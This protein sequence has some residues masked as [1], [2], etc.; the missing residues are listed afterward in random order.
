MN[1]ETAFSYIVEKTDIQITGV[2]RLW[3]IRQEQ[4]SLMTGL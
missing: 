3:N 2:N 4:S 1:Y